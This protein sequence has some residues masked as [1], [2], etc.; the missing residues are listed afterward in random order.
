MWLAPIVGTL[1]MF[2]SVIAAAVLYAKG[3]QSQ[4]E[5][6]LPWFTIGEWSN[7]I[8]IT[9]DKLSLPMLSMV[10]LISFLVHLYSVGFMA[11]DRHAGRYF[12]ALGFFTFSMLGLVISGNLL[13]LFCFWEL[14]G[15]SS[16]LLIGHWRNR[17]LAGAAAT[18]AFIFNRVGD[19]LFIIGIGLSFASANSLDISIIAQSHLSTFAGICIFG[20]VAGKSAQFPLLNW[21]PDAMEGPTPVSAL[22]H[23]ATMVAAGVYLLLRM[24]FILSPEVSTVIAI[25]GAITALY[26]GWIALQQFDLKRILAY[27]TISQLGLMMLAIG[28]GSEDGAFVHLLSHALFKACLFLAAGAIIHSLYHVAHEKEF[29][30]QDIRNM[31]G[32]YKERPKLFIATG[33]ALAALCGLPLFSGFISKEMIVVPMIHRAR[34]T[35]DLLMWLYVIIFFI[36]SM[37]TVLYSYRL[38]VNVFF[39]SR[40]TSIADLSPTPPVMQWPVSL[41]AVL[42]LWI[43]FSLNP[44]GPGMFLQWIDTQSFHT[45]HP[46]SGIIAV[47]SIVWLLV[48]FGL[49]W[50][51]FTYHK[52]EFHESFSLDKVYD[53]LFV[54]SSLRL[55]SFFEKFDKDVI[56]S[57]VH[58]FVYTQVIIAKTSGYFD[59]YIIDGSVSAVVWISRATGNLLRGGTAGR[60]QSYLTW[61][62]IALIIFIFW[63]FK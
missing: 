46:K 39:G 16:Y 34:E 8:I 19:A 23:A 45:L 7:D 42:S 2:V 17:P 20:G 22:I 29:N 36:S 28:A 44:T 60:V 32:F 63:L 21:I 10:V 52:A 27:S 9:A 15:F 41:L 12:A 14:V 5:V 49:A 56:D 61:S 55:S 4:A 51:L 37:L 43:F 33:I 35:G 48:S 38:F 30:P 59:R 25:T 58:G 18:K 3:W 6:R 26:G 54:S 13:V 47:V 40:Q 53:K 50:Y 1:L 31:G 57:V 62:A 11:D 24:P